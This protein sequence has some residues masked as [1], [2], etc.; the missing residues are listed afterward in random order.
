LAANNFCMFIGALY[1]SHH[2]CLLLASSHRKY[3]YA[4][5]VQLWRLRSN[6]LSAPLLTNALPYLYPRRRLC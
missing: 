5:T 2:I 1:I 3:T 4:Y 6:S